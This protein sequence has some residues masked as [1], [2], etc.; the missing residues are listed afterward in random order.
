MKLKLINIKK[1]EEKE[2]KIEQIRKKL[3]K[4]KWKF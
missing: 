1:I 3:N 4:K 2:M